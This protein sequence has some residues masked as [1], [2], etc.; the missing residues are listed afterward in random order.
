MGD[1]ICE[2][3][4][5]PFF[6]WIEDEMDFPVGNFENFAERRLCR[7]CHFEA[8][9]YFLALNRY[10]DA[11]GDIR[12]IKGIYNPKDEEDIVGAISDYMDKRADETQREF[13][14]VFVFV[15]IL[16]FMFFVVAPLVIFNGYDD[17]RANR[18]NEVKL[19]MGEQETILRGQKP[20]SHQQAY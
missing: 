5:I 13:K 11:G 8:M 6:A 4:G 2:S 15:L 16:L 3:C 18:D 7:K 9:R 17:W 14:R 20:S 1:C 10:I 12:N 19:M